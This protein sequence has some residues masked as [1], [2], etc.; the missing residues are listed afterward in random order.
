MSNLF[1]YYEFV[2]QLISP[3]MDKPEISYN[4][5]TIYINTFQHGINELNDNAEVHQL[6]LEWSFTCYNVD[7]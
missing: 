4:H 3:D 5:S 2:N 6:S 7:N 1:K